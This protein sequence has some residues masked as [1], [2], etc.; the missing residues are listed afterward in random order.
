MIQEL[1]LGNY[2]KIGV[3][4]QNVYP[5]QYGKVTQIY[6]EGGTIDYH[7]PLRW[8]EKIPLSP[9]ILE[10]C[11]GFYRTNYK[12]PNHEYFTYQYERFTYNSLHGWW[13][14]QRR[15]EVQPLFLHELQ[16]LVWILTKQE[17]IFKP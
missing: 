10:K 14:H 4:F 6:M 12:D 5:A 3:N 17:L 16:N 15:L 13:F 7:Y 9:E 2:F 8:F 11:E 1:R